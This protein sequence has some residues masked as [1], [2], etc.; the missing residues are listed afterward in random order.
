MRNLSMATALFVALVAAA[1]ASALR[2]EPCKGQR[3]FSCGVL[4]QPLDHATPEGA[5]VHLRFAVQRGK[6]PLLI[7][8][9]GGPGQPG[10]AYA[11]SFRYSLGP[12]LQRYRLLVLDQRGTGK[13][14]VLNCPNLQ[15]LGSLADVGPEDLAA[16]AERIGPRRAFYSTV[17]SVEDVEGL[18]V[19]LGASKVALMGISYGTF[20]AQQ[21]ARLHPATTRALILD[22]VV[23]ADGPDPF[24]IDS[25]AVTPRVLAE[26]CARARCRGVTNDPLGDVGALLAELPL[27]GRTFDARGRA[28][29]TRYRRP[30]EIVN[31][32]VSADL[33][34]FLQAALPG[35]IASALRGDSAELLRLRAIA[36]GGPTPL[37]D[38]SFA[39]NVT[40]ACEDTALPYALTTPVALRD[41]A[42]AAALAAIPPE[43][44][45]PFSADTVLATSPA[46]DCSRLPQ[47]V[48]NTPSAE[49]LP[50]I[51]VLLLSGRL[52]MRT[53]MENAAQLAEEL[54]RATVV[55]VAGTGHDVLDQDITGCAAIVLSRW[56]RAK[57]VGTPC[58]GKSNQVAVLPRPP[59][60]LSDFRSAPGV[61][62][63]RGRALFAVL[64]TATDAR[65][66]M[67]ANYFSGLPMRGGGL[68][69]G[70][71]RATDDTLQLRRYAYVPGLRLS[72]RLRLTDDGD[73]TGRVRVDGPR[74]T[75][76]SL[77]L[78][79]DGSAA[80]RLGGRA[81]AY[82][83][84]RAAAARVQAVAPLTAALERFPTR[85]LRRA[86]AADR[87][88]HR[89]TRHS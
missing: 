42:T 30:D 54:P 31:L 87:R 46:Q 4:T 34:P 68:R 25:Y 20:V 88:D 32:I 18:R 29:T 9:S 59:R 76:G 5:K 49:P 78:Y 82:R 66:T 67:F 2:L 17:D 50:D 77:R 44:Y 16:C 27:R 80:G 51:P 38:L 26:Q 70:S 23:G 83:R 33:N 65:T 52:D 61:G 71:F 60:S 11:E 64:D 79:A 63:V 73:L 89:G 41:D 22:S 36:D 75:S 8:L 53:P 58:S 72:G 15:K 43:S 84:K 6:K 13:S 62:G 21:Y 85:L 1:P 74:G 81:V 56:A 39:L 86:R 55:R 47:D 37:A 28:Q 10:V 19:A 14:G 12:A 7:A 3:G 24:Y 40:T 35:A 48:V 69:G 57:K 45:R